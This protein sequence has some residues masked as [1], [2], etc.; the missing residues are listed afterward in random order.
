MKNKVT[1]KMV[2]QKAGVATSTVS[3]AISGKATISEATKKRVF[4]VMEEL[5]YHPNAIAKSLVNS[6]SKNIGII[7]P[8][9]SEEFL[10][11]PFFQESLRGISMI[12][13]KEEYD[14]LI[15]YS[16]QDELKAVERLVI[17]NKV[18][19]FILMRSV[20][21][22]R[23]IKYLREI[24]IPYV[25]IGKSLD[26]DDI[27]EVDTDN[28]KV[29]EDV[30]ENLVSNNYKKIAFIG[31]DLSSVVTIERLQGYKNGLKKANIPFDEKIAVMGGFNRHEG[32][33]AM[34]QIISNNNAIDCVLVTDS[35]MYNGAISYIAEKDY[36]KLNEM[37]F[38][39]FGDDVSGYKLGNKSV[40]ANVNSRKL[41]S[42]ACEKLISI[43]RD[44]V[45][46]RRTTVDYDIEL[47]I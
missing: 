2:A 43:I 36:K 34:E 27:Y 15:G 4:E 14:I 23:I 25:L 47:N 3:R 1:I 44:E 38:V 32:F 33:G 22:D 29:I 40:F 39:G 46:E 12:A 31:G 9:D 24:N 28:V 20:L 45:V 35:L 8:T 13:G 19:G 11:N 37:C 7:L 41:G 5:N 26:Y 42:K 17:S 21:N 10:M 6:E 30:M 16:N 18:D